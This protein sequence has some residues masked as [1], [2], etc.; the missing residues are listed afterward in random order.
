MVRPVGTQFPGRLRGRGVRAYCMC[1]SLI[2]VYTVTQ[3]D[4]TRHSARLGPRKRSFPTC[5]S[6]PS[7]APRRVLPASLGPGPHVGPV[8]SGSTVR[9]P[10]PCPCVRLQPDGQRPERGLRPP[11]RCTTLGV[12]AHAARHRSRT[13]GACA[14]IRSEAQLERSRAARRGCPAFRT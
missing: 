4:R 12:A 7:R 6:R 8:A 11:A 5:H 3:P 14:P 13:P 10:Y 9:G 1:E 2:I